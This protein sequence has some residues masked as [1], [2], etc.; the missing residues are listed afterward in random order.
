VDFATSTALG[1]IG[2]AG[3]STVAP[4][5]EQNFSPGWSLHPHSEQNEVADDGGSETTA[6]HPE[7]NFSPDSITVSHLTHF[8]TAPFIT[9]NWQTLPIYTLT[10]PSVF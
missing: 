8:I 10:I 1:A 9:R 2:T 7:Q 3:T 5:S 4:H 6:P